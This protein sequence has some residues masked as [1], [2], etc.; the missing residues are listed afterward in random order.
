MP[1]YSL[2]YSISHSLTHSLIAYGEAGRSP[3]IP[4]DTHIVCHIKILKI[5]EDSSESDEIPVLFLK[6][7]GKAEGNGGYNIYGLPHFTH[8]YFSSTYSIAHESQVAAI[9]YPNQ[10]LFLKSK[11]QLVVVITQ[12]VGKSRTRT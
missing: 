6:N 12:Q 1:I 5:D 3:L 8:L 2:P 9:C 11:L 10:Q 4:A 7:D